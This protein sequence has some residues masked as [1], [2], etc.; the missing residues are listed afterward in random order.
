M[1]PTQKMLV[2][3]GP[4]LALCWHFLRS[5]ALLGGILRFLLRLSRL[6]DVFFAS[7]R[8][9]NSN[10]EGFGRVRGRF[11][12]LQACILRGF[13]TPARL[14]RP[15]ALNVTKPQF[16]WVGT[17]FYWVAR[18]FAG[19]AH[20]TRNREKSLQKPFERNCPRQ[21]RPKCALELAGLVF[22][23]VWEPS[24]LVLGAS[25]PLLGRFGPLLGVSWVTLNRILGALGRIWALTD[26]SRLDFEG[27]R[28][29]PGKVFES[30]GALFRSFCMP[31]H[32]T[33]AKTYACAL[34]T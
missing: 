32:G 27:F 34:Q 25:W 29:A 4:M 5:W 13:C 15:I 31:E 28:E 30:P 23:E 26:G 17:Q 8:A 14:H 3:W 24:G 10:L 19:N 21:S 1:P 11:W 12:S 33:T 7:W 22:G 20:H 6:L 2:P 16:Y 9:Q 18:H